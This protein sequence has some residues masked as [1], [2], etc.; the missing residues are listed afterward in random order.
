MTTKKV[1]RIF[2]LSDKTVL[3]FDYGG[4]YILICIH[5]NAY[6]YTLQRQTF[7]YTSYTLI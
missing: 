4:V 5:Q 1:E 3:C 6:N 7:L 2:F